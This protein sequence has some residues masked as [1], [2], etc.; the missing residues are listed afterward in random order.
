[1]KTKAQ[2]LG[3]TDFPYKEYDKN[4]NLTYYEKNNGNWW[5]YGYDERGY[6]SHYENCLGVWRNVK[7]DNKGDVIYTEYSVNYK[8]YVII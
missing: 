4:V 5:K 3:I 7:Y 8:E 2:E 1:M 6:R